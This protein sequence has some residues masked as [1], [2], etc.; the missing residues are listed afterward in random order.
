[1]WQLAPDRLDQLTDNCR[2]LK[3]DVLIITESKLDQ[4]IPDNL[5]TIPGYHE[6]IRRD[7]DINGRYG[8]VLLMYIAENLVFQ[9]KK[10][11]NLNIMSIYGLMSD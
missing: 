10:I 11:C 2:I 6:P 8:G 9:Q 7:R 1:M 4:N 3:I 5:I